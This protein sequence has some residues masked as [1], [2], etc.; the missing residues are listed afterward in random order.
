MHPVFR[1]QGRKVSDAAD[2][3]FGNCGGFAFLK[4][5][6]DSGT[7]WTRFLGQSEGLAPLVESTGNKFMKGAGDGMP[8]TQ[9]FRYVCS[10]SYR[11][12]AVPGL[13]G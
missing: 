5:R 7:G 6:G 8:R 4:N 3:C 11:R 12:Q 9:G 2:G 10:D 13:S 1:L